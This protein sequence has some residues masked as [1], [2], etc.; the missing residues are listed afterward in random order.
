[1]NWRFFGVAFAMVFF[2]C[3]NRPVQA[4]TDAVYAVYTI[5]GAEDRENIT[6]LMRFYEG[7]RT[8]TALLL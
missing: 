4:G 1:M 7:R 6:C 3:N 8:G 5:S 2:S